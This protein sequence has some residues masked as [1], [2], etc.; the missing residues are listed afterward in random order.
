MEDKSFYTH[1][2]FDI[3]GIM[4]ALLDDIRT[5]SFARGGSTIT[6]QLAKI[7]FTDSKKTIRRKI[8]EL[9]C[10]IEIEKR[11]TKDEILNLYLNS[12]D[13]GHLNYGIESASHFY[14]NKEVFDLDI[15]EVSLLVGMIPSPPRYSP[16]L[17]RERS[18]RK[19]RIV[20]RKLVDAG[21]ADAEPIVDE[22][23]SFWEH[24]N[25]LEHQPNVSFWSMEKVKAPYFVEYL[26][27]T[28]TKELGE[29]R[30]KEGGLKVFT[31][32]DLEKQRIAE[33][34]LY[35]G[36]QLQAVR[37]SQLLNEEIRKRVEGALI[38]LD[39][40]NGHILVMVGGSGFTFENQFNRAL[41]SSRQVGSAFKPFIYASA[42]EAKGYAKNTQM[43]DRPLE[44]Q[45][46]NGVWKPENY[47][48]KYYG[49]VSLEKALKMSLNSVAVQLLLDTG[50][51]KVIDI[52]GRALD[53]EESEIEKR[54]KPY[55]SIALGVYSFSPLELV[56][57]YA[58]FPNRGEKVFPLSIIRVEDLNGKVLIDNAKTFKRLRT[59]YDLNNNLSVINLATA[60]TINEML[61]AV[62]KKGGTAYH[63]ISTS[64]LSINGSGKTGTTNG[65][66]DA[67]FIGYT[68]DIVA[69][70]WVGFD[71]PAYSLGKGQTGGTVAAPIWANFMKKALWRE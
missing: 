45:T 12:I 67:W 5:L 18:R 69:T 65:Y 60:E 15:Y 2:G 52:I 1:S 20:L 7:L 21:I 22:L 59:Y 55:P 43:V 33:D 10:T 37:S 23:D 41:S 25:T 48:Q 3:K 4:A 54:F 28:L 68:R 50:P 40:R 63:A 8:Y 35:Q 16:L 30:V 61:S 36:L 58:I 24:F 38:A 9:F 39:P 64:G 53:L 51:E 34:T 42:I 49:T 14:F 26:R 17:Y 62:L 19:Q 27:Q 56:K 11:F 70:V 29:E 32:L 71:N 6:Q 47:D 46:N 13:Y 66:T 31:T 57:A 44:I